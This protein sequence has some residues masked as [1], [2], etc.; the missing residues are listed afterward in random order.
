MTVFVNYLLLDCGHSVYAS[1]GTTPLGP[2][3]PIVKL[4]TV[5]D[6]EALETW[7]CPAHGEQRIVDIGYTT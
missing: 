6:V 7:V 4:A 3:K 5:A 2:E 1:G